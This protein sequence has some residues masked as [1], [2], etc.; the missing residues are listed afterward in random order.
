MAPSSMAHDKT[1]SQKPWMVEV[2]T[3]KYWTY[4]P[5]KTSIL[6]EDGDGKVLLVALNTPF[7]PK[8]LDEEVIH[9]ELDIVFDDG[10]EVVPIIERECREAIAN[11][12]DEVEPL[13]TIAE[14]GEHDMKFEPTISNSGKT[15]FKSIV[16]SKLNGNPFLSKDLLTQIRNSMNFNNDE[17]YLNVASLSST[18]LLGLGSDCGVYF[19]EKNSLDTPS[20]V[21]IA[22]KRARTTSSRK[23]DPNNVDVGLESGTW[24][25]RRVQKMRH[26]VGTKWGVSQNYID[27][28]NSS[29]G[30]KGGSSPVAQALLNWFSKGPESNKFKHNASNM[31]WIDV[32]SIISTVTL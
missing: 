12:L 10:L 20:T 32:D 8:N 31:Q 7:L 15:I 24:W 22:C 2:A 16:V 4:I 9:L 3:V 6:E 30:K 26:R 25:I 23:Q 17:D 28:M 11:I 5:P 27:L 14:A 21:Q 18:C 13:A 19:V 29:V 1:K